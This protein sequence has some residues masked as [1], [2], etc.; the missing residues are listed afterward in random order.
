MATLYRKYRPQTFSD[1][2]GQDHIRST[3]RAALSLGRVGHAY[4]FT[5]PRGVGK[6]TVAR[7]LAKAV[8]CRELELRIKNDKSRKKDHRRDVIQDIEPCNQCQSC[9]EITDGRSLDVLEIDAASNR[10][11]DEIRELRERIK[12]AP[13]GSPKK[14]FIIDEVHMLTKEAFNALLKT[15]EEPPVHAIFIL[16][17]TELHKVPVTIA[18]RCQVFM[19]K[20]A[21]NSDLL[22]RLKTIADK[23]K[24]AV[25]AGAL[26]FLASMSDGSFR[27]A[28]SLLDQVASY[29][30][31][32]ISLAVVHDVL[33]LAT[34]D[35]VLTIL[36]AMAAGNKEQ[37]INEL[38]T[39]EADGLDLENFAG[40]LI[41]AGRRLLHVNLGTETAKE[42]ISDEYRPRWEKVAESWNEAELLEFIENLV[43]ARSA[44]KQIIVPVLSLEL[45]VTKFSKP[46]ATAREK[47]SDIKERDNNIKSS[48]KNETEKDSGEVPEIELESDSSGVELVESAKPLG[49]VN[50]IDGS[51]ANLWKNLLSSSKDVNAGLYAILQQAEFAG[52]DGDNLCIKVPFQFAADRLR[53][54]KYHLLMSELI[55][56]NFNQSLSLSCSVCTEKSHEHD[57]APTSDGVNLVDAAIEALGVEGA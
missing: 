9:L 34:E 15:L 5:G 29:E 48:P 57:T 22:S 32:E 7:L 28:L 45:V 41:E 25:E 37:S 3:L 17:T 12:F 26:K 13:S 27:D 1:L 54:K 2:V 35:R 24:L 16:A 55:Q 52:I 36:E 11:I 14:V 21:R 51:G 31:G 39:M 49:S 8:N 42:I 50:D 47:K 38:A 4:L 20:K 40:Q 33:G 6:T 10:G 43:A 23:E 18:S 56:K 53:D 19:F 46:R 30:H 44:M